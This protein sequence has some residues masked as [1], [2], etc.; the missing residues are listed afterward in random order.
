MQVEGNAPS[1]VSKDRAK[2]FESRF[3]G[4]KLESYDGI[5]VFAAPG[6]HEAALDALRQAVPAGSRVLE[7]GAGGGALSRRLRDAGYEVLACDLFEANFTPRGEI[8]FKAI[9]LNAAFADALPGGWDAIVSVEVIEHI[10]NP[11]NFARECARL[12]ADGGT[13]VIS[14]PNIANPVS[15]AMFLLR[16]HFQWFD[17]LNYVEQGHISP[18]SPQLL[19][20]CFA[21]SGFALQVE[22][23]VASP[24]RQLKSLRKIGLRLTAALL[25]LLSA[26]DARMKGEVYL[27]V[28]R[29][30]AAPSD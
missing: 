2:S 30:G 24:F 5:P 19:Q 9:D 22:R 3:Q 8:P 13:C 17:D 7:L 23:T 12:L 20:R 28:W 27:G 16:G 6:V 14:T 18:L 4:R 26:A 15:Q 21:E 29:R 10:E 1:D 11:R 25:S